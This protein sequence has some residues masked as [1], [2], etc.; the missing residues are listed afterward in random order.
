MNDVIWSILAAFLGAIGGYYARK[1]LGRYRVNDSET[2]AS[3][4]LEDAE[5]EAKVK[6]TA[7]DLEAKNEALKAR[8]E[9]EAKTLQK[10][11][12]LAQLEER[13]AQRED[14][15]DR[16]LALIDK[17]ET[18]LDT[19]LAD[20]E[21][22]QEKLEE[23][24]AAVAAAQERATDQLQRVAGMTRD[25]AKVELL[26][27][28]NKELESETGALIRRSQ[29]HAK[30]DANRRASQIIALAVQ[31]YAG[32]HTNELMMSS[33]SLPGDDMKGRVIG[34]EGRNI[35]CLES[36]TGVNV[37]IDDSP[38]S[39][40]ITGFDPVRREIARQALEML[41]ADGRIHPARIEEVVEQV[42]Q[43]ME[44]T[45]RLAGEDAIYKVGIQDVH[46]DLLRLL[47]RLRYRTSYTQ[48]VLDHSIEVAHIIGM[49]ASEMGLD[50]G[51]AKRVGLFHDIGKAVD[52]EIEGG[53]AIIGA[54]I[55]KKAGECAEVV[56]GVAAHHADVEASGP[57]ALLASAADA[58][59]SSR[60]GARSET[61]E[62][63]IKRLERL[64]SI[65]NSYA[66]VKKTYAIQ[67]GREVRVFVEPDQ[68]DDNQA[69]ILA[70]SISKQ[71]QEELK[72]PG[73]I[74]IVVIRETRCVE[75]AR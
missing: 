47:G 53:H 37:L 49:L 33:V 1:N 35:R 55:L 3:R 73:Q 67:A 40:V 64:E 72:Y 5:R 11:Q 23:A 69:V 20:V 16:K 52:H 42:K 59:S 26:D 9:F 25:Q 34:R 15:L 32:K 10:R 21:R 60:P 65:A 12:E 62:L 74:R 22:R 18:S 70:R 50:V 61:T 54:D 36:L 66:G 38:D 29:E 30:E 7:A 4:I 51:I 68:V 48:N 17:K 14:N 43:N 63:Y 71:I 31:R 44:E 28:V 41:V 57:Y 13:L 75:F 56:N 19:K 6:L 8:D 27:R 58:I 39:V 46:P 24:K 45:I 2:R